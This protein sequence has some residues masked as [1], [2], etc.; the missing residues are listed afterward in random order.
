MFILSFFYIH[1]RNLLILLCF[2]VTNSFAQIS[3]TF[4]DND[5]ELDPAW[6]GDT[7]N[8]EVL[9]QELHLQAPAV[10]DVSYLSSPSES[11]NNA[12]WEFYIRLEFN[13]SSSNFAK[14][15]L[16]SD[17]ANLKGE[18]HGY[19]VRIGS[20]ADDIS[21]YRQDGTSHILVI[22][23]V[24]GKLGLSTVEANI[25][26]TRDSLGN[27]E[28]FSDVGLTG[29]YVSEGSAY[30][31]EF[32]KSSFVGPV[33]NYTSTRADK[34]YFDNISISGEPWVD[35]EP[36]QLIYFEILSPNSLILEFDEP[37]LPSSVSTTQFNINET[38]PV[39]AEIDILNQSQ[40]MLEFGSD[41]NNGFNHTLKFENISDTLG[42]A[43]LANYLEFLYFVELPINNG[44]VIINEFFPDPSPVIQLPESEFLELLNVSGNPI[45]LSGWTL[46]DAGTTAVLDSMLLLP[47]SILILS[48][49][50]YVNS[51]SMFGNSIGISPW[52]SQNNSGDVLTLK[53]REGITIDSISY[54]TSWYHDE[55]KE[56]GGYTLERIN[57]SLN[58]FLA[59]NWSASISDSG[60]T[61]GTLNSIYSIVPDTIAPQIVT[62]HFTTPKRINISLSEQVSSKDSVNFNMNPEIK[63]DSIIQ[64]NGGMSLSVFL[65]DSI[66]NE[67]AYVVILSGPTDCSGNKLDSQFQLSLDYLPPFVTGIK[68]IHHNEFLVE[69]SEP[70]IAATLTKSNFQINNI[71]ASKI[72]QVDSLQA[73]LEFEIE[74]MN[75]AYYYLNYS[76]LKD[77]KNNSGSGSFRFSYNELPIPGF[78]DLIVSEIMIDPEPGLGILPNSQYIE[79]Y[80]RTNQ[81]F[82]LKGIQLGDSKSSTIIKE[83]IINGG[84][85][86]IVVPSTQKSAFESFSNVIGL[87]NWPTFNKSDDEV[88]LRSRNG[89]MLHTLAYSVEWYKDLEKEEGGWSLEII[90]PNNPCG[91]I[92]NWTSAITDNGGTPGTK[93]SV[94]NEN[95]DNFPPVLLQTTPIDSL[96]LYA[97]FN[98]SLNPLSTPQIQIEPSMGILNVEF[99]NQAFNEVY[100]FLET[101][102]IFNIPYQLTINVSDCLGNAELVYSE[103]IFLPQQAS[104]NDIIINE[105][106]FN[107]E[108]SQSDF[109]EVYNRSQKYITLESWTL[110]SYS[111]SGFVTGG[112]IV[113]LQNIM[114]PGEYIVLTSDTESFRHQYPFVDLQRILQV[115]LP[116]LPDEWAS[117]TLANGEGDLIDSSYYH[118]DWHHPLLE[119][120]E[121]V[122]LE[123]RSSEE[124]SLNSNNWKSASS[125]SGFSTPGSL[126]S[127][128]FDGNPIDQN[129]RLSPE[130]IFPDTAGPDSFATIQYA[131]ERTGIVA[132]INVFN[133]TG[134]RIR[135]LA[136]NQ[137]LSSSGI[138]TWDGTDEL[139]NKVTLGHYFIVMDLF[140]PDGY[141]KRIRKKIA[142]G[143]RR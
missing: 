15:Y 30:D 138:F 58:C 27:W 34:F 122:S 113:S 59:S 52:P 47:D 139:G 1:M 5:L 62:A 56:S 74:F 118:E 96:T 57:P 87:A 94:W 80:N 70:P 43:T 140:A 24:D 50:S 51:F 67:T 93:N 42:N 85:Y 39:L 131:F 60:G 9:F 106:L 123:R 115:K 117:I 141:K 14:F 48:P 84:A 16:V 17:S 38:N 22:D 97:R 101:P 135:E 7:S 124:S 92:S 71:S 46:S 136:V 120:I 21:L 28:L 79:I 73:L 112:A 26:V 89:E 63:Y 110:S 105:V 108:P 99:T 116:S 72:S 37:L 102:M 3:D 77:F 82:S 6:S 83:G 49:Y 76:N 86:S 19:Y 127:Q 4:S 134:V 78:L 31:E 53:N 20:T 128:N 66:N 61:P 75:G 54:T 90:D 25:L 129:V 111:E 68:I 23:G 10:A 81:P 55:E 133:A 41:F 18:V 2:A 40:I 33:C 100:I 12:T 109:I 8:F 143:T 64:D 44:D 121:G 95:P 114:K 69:F 130:I 45:Q 35:H 104:F 13:S 29:T 137:L 125:T 65:S 103:N 91:G 126:N 98:E 132:S 11:I 142:I 119:T 36:P 107:P 32:I 88:A